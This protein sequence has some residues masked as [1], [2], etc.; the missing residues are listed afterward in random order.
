MPLRRKIGL[1]LLL[2]V[3]VFGCVITGIKA[4]QLRNLDGHDN[5]TGVSI[6]VRK[7]GSNLLTLGI[8]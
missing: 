1:M 7:E 6:V 2:G 4:Y 8:V 5:M 3:G